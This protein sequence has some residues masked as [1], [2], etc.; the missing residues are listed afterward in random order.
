MLDNRNAPVE[1]VKYCEENTKM[2]DKEDCKGEKEI[3]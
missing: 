3:F 2:N 1:L